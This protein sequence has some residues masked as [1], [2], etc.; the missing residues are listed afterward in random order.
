MWYKTKITRHWDADT[1]KVVSEH[2]IVQMSD[3]GSD[4][5]DADE[6][7]R[8]GWDSGTYFW[9]EAME[10]GNGDTRNPYQRERDELLEERRKSK[11]TW[12][13]SAPGS[14]LEARAKADVERLEHRLATLH[15]V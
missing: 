6:S 7:E 3:N 2:E 14:E 8:K 12:E 10:I 9:L 4:W 11:H 15:Q 5:R 1:R 13:Y